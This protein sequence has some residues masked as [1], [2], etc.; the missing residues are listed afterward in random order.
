M[1][2][3]GG[4]PT[5]KFF[6]HRTQIIFTAP[7]HRTEHHSAS[8]TKQLPPEVAGELESFRPKRFYLKARMPQGYGCSPYRRARFRRH[9]R[10]AIILEITDAD[11][12]QIVTSGP[13]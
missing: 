13:T 7:G 12:L 3:L 2:G 9:R 11:A 5:A 4:H 1:T 10:A 8:D 6:E